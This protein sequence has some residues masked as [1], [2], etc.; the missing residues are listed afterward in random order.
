MHEYFQ[1][2]GVIG[3]IIVAI[4]V[5]LLG[6]ESSENATTAI[7][8]SNALMEQSNL[9]LEKSN[10]LLQETN[11]IS[12]KQFNLSNSERI[13]GIEDNQSEIIIENIPYQYILLNV[14]ENIISDK[15][16]KLNYDV[17]FHKFIYGGALY[18][19]IS[20]MI[21]PL[22]L[23]EE[24][25]DQLMLENLM[26]QEVVWDSLLRQH[27]YSNVYPFF[28]DPDIHDSLSTK[29][30]GL[31][32]KLEHTDDHFERLNKSSQTDGATFSIGEIRLVLSHQNLGSDI[33]KKSDEWTN[34]AIKNP[35]YV[36]SVV[37]NLP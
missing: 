10:L 33:V 32:L 18:E 19:D 4:I 22:L 11:V 1:T 15:K 9:L 16:I 26:S 29:Q 3:A 28:F 13:V 24:K 14:T 35:N 7:E 27:I 23:D 30:I 36:E 8:R 6:I 20:V 31:I 37:D 2:G 21:V 12:Q 25:N 17:E 34:L 5:G